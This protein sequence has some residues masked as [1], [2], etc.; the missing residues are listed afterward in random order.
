[1]TVSTGTIFCDICSLAYNTR[2]NPFPP[3]ISRP[4]GPLKL[5]I[6]PGNG[7]FNILTTKRE[8]IFFRVCVRL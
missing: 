4:N 7:S 3:R 2:N 8:D 6:N 5:S 1:M